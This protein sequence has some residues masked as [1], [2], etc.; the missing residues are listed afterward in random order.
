MGSALWNRIKPSIDAIVFSN[1]WIS[2]GALSLYLTCKLAFGL[3][4]IL[5]EA[6]LVFSASCIGYNLLK[7]KGLNLEGNQSIF[8][9]WMRKHKFQTYF[10]MFLSGLGLLYALSEISFLQLFVL[11]LSAFFALLYLGFERF[12]LRSFW[13]LKTQIVAFVWALFI[14][15][16]AMV[17]YYT[18]FN[19]VGQVILF[20]SIF[21]FILGLTIPFDIRDWK[22]DEN[23]PNMRT[24]P[25]LFGLKGTLVIAILH[26]ILAF[27]CAL[28]FN[29]YA[30]LL[31]PLLVVAIKIIYGL[32]TDSSEYN[33]TFGLDGIIILI[34][35]LLWLGK[36]IF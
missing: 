19:L 21:F 28:I 27:V 25:M 30:I 23:D 10:V 22:A 11:G 24:L 2:L 34:Y 32:N 8:N 14:L 6:V 35:P 36:Q 12:N 1:I 13:F 4:V 9:E 17:D 5:Y 26:L 31:L 29:F 7:L 18:Q 3:S 33:Y 16:I 20:A 15:G